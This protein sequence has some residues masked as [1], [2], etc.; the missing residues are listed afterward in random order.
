MHDGYKVGD[1]WDGKNEVEIRGRCH[2]CHVPESM[3]HILLEC[4]ETGQREIWDLAETMWKSREGTPEWKQMSVGAIL[5]CG[6]TKWC[7]KEGRPDKGLSRFYR[8]L[9]SEASYTI[10]K[11][12]NER[13]IQH[14]GEIGHT[15]KTVK[16]RFISAINE[17]LTFDR[18]QTN[19]R[20]WGKKAISVGLVLGT[21]RGS[22]HDEQNLPENWIRE[23]GVLVGI[24]PEE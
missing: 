1:Y 15:Q 14:G 20:R 9:V 7:D 22:L 19:R 6:L 13:V 2:R 8:I 12:R 3:E 16:N 21:W 4:E 18:L 24:L 5:S 23:S 11:L 17:R 10:W